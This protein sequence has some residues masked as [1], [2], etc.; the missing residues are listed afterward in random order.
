VIRLKLLTRPGCGL[1]D[2]MRREVDE[3][4]GEAPRSWEV[5]NVDED[6]ALAS[7]YGETIP[8]LFVNGHL[9]AKVR[10]PRLAAGLR[11]QRA[12]ARSAEP[13]TSEP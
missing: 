7:R 13:P 10:L 8:V 12:V 1:C 3:L 2:E 4:L 9:F 5:V 6:P 11:L